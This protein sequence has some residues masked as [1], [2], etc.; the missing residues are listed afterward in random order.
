MLLSV[1]I[2]ISAMG[3]MQLERFLCWLQAAHRL[4][5]ATAD[6]CDGKT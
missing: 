4:L 3:S 6:T 1:K 5:E 2:A